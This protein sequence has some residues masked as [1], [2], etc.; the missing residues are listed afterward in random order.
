MLPLVLPCLLPIST[1]S[2]REM[3]AKHLEFISFY[4]VTRVLLQ[5]LSQALFAPATVAA[6]PTTTANLL[7]ASSE[8]SP[9][10]EIA[11]AN[12]ECAFRLSQI[13]RNHSSP[14]GEEWRLLCKSMAP[15]SGNS[16][17]NQ[18]QQQQ[19]DCESGSQQEVSGCLLVVVES[20]AEG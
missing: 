11:S 19:Q 15:T 4:L 9:L 17:S 20:C 7:P 3:F 1:T 2:K 16:E 12:L 13:L 10:F 5:S 6:T 18:I 14:I 8:L